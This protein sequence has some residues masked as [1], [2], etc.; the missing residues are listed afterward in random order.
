MTGNR[1]EPEQGCEVSDLLAS[2]SKEVVLSQK[3]GA[4]DCSDDRDSVSSLPSTLAAYIRE[5]H[6]RSGGITVL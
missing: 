2:P 1:N 5:E 4:L 3:N 6:K